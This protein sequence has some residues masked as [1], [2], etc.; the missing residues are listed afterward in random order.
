MLQILGNSNLAENSTDGAICL[1]K[2][3]KQDQQIVCVIKLKMCHMLT[4]FKICPRAEV[5]S[6]FVINILKATETTSL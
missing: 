4:F 6:N 1:P 2:G 5:K 3:T